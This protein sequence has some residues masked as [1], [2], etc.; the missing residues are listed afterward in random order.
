MYCI[1]RNVY[2]IFILNRTLEKSEAVK[3]YIEVVRHYKIL[4]NRKLR[5]F[6]SYFWKCIE[7]RTQQE[8]SKFLD[9]IK[10]CLEIYI[11]QFAEALQKKYELS[12]QNHEHRNSTRQRYLTVAFNVGIV[13]YVFFL[14]KDSLIFIGLPDIISEQVRLKLSRIRHINSN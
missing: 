12:Q 8:L 4:I 1:L 2:C 6:L 5:G 10:F 14:E 7:I 3:G 13:S 11:L 9:K